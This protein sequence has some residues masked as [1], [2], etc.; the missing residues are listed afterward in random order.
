MFSV[1][2]QQIF[3][4]YRRLLRQT[5]G[6]GNAGLSVILSYKLYLFKIRKFI[7]LDVIH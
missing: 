3:S 6:L 2:K 7:T 4:E 5:E 1:K